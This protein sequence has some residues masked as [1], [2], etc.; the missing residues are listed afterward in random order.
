MFQSRFGKMDQFG[1]LDLEIITADAGTQITSTEFKD[2][3]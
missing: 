1:W 2:E 3:C